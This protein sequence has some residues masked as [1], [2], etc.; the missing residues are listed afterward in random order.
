MLK[1]KHHVRQYARRVTISL[2]AI[3]CLNS[4]TGIPDGVTPVK[5][6]EKDK[7]LGKWHEIAR[8][9]HSFERGLNNVTAQYSMRKDGGIKVV[10]RGFSPKKERW[11]ES[12]GK[13]YFVSDKSTGHLKVSFFGPF[14]GSYVIYHLDKKDYQYSYVTGPNRKYLWFLSRTPTVS[15]EQ[16]EHFVKT[17]KELGYNTDA[18]IFVDQSKNR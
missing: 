2:T 11:K 13:A 17:A 15:K 12:V 3:I 10:N 5:G 1:L 6:I 16:K 9:D 8:L 4:C 14:Y 7:Y 18:L